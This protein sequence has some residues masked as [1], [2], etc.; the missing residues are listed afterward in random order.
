MANV[1]VTIIGLGRMGASF[2][3]A[4]K[5]L[6][7]KPEVKHTFSITG[8]D[9]TPAKI[10][11]AAKLSAL[12]AEQANIEESV[13][14][15][16]IV[17]VTAPFGDVEAIYELIG[18]A[19]KPGAVVIDCAPIKTPSVAWAKKYFRR[20]EAGENVAYLVGLTPVINPEYLG[21]AWEETAA[22][23]P[24]LFTNGV[25]F[26]VPAADCPPEAVRLVSDLSDL[27][28]V[29]VHFSDPA[30]HD[31]MVA[32][33]E[34]LPALLQLAYFRSL[35]NSSSWQ[36][37]Q[38]L[39]NPAFFLATHQLAEGDP[40]ALGAAAYHNRRNLIA[41]VDAVMEALARLREALTIDDADLMPEYYDDAMKKYADWQSAR[42]RNRWSTE[43][44]AIEK[45]E[46]RGSMNLFG[47][48]MPSFGGR[49]KK[50][51]K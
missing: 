49:K 36:D 21:E 26:I 29:K 42:A 30:E 33:T 2:G 27:L 31:G 8:S 3:L 18:P 45:S 24:D 28:N 35:V 7:G 11:A 46:L 13:R 50:D 16:D 19:L 39:S 37:S 22:A 20:N 15:A 44:E 1:S 12:D 38:W 17:I 25:F 5:A 32:S 10:K 9:K 34:G 43:P 51:K 41:K 23:R 47:P 6:N 48:L 40:M 4:L 14:G